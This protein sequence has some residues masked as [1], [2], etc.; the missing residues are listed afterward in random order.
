MKIRVNLIEPKP[1]M[2]GGMMGMMGN[3]EPMIPPG[4]E[5]LMARHSD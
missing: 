1:Q 2:G 5:E 3:Q 4:M